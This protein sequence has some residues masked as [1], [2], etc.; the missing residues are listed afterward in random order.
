MKKVSILMF[1]F[2]LTLFV[3]IKGT[4]AYVQ[5]YDMEFTFNKT[6]GYE[7]F[8][9]VERFTWEGQDWVKLVPK[10]GS[11]IYDIVIGFE[12]TSNRLDDD[13]V[14]YRNYITPQEMT[15]IA[16]YDPRTIDYT[17]QFD[18]IMSGAM[19]MYTYDNAINMNGELLSLGAH[20]YNDELYIGFDSGTYTDGYIDDLIASDRER[21]LTVYYSDTQ[22]LKP[23]TVREEV[24]LWLQA[25]YT[26]LTYQEGY[27]VG[28]SEGYDDGYS[29]GRTA[30]IN[31]VHNEYIVEDDLNNDGFGDFSYTQ[32]FNAFDVESFKQEVWRSQEFLAKIEEARNE[33]FA[34]GYESTEAES[35]ILQFGGGF[36]GSA[37]TFVFALLT[38]FELFGI[39]GL[40]V[41]I[42]FIVLGASVIALKFIF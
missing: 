13:T 10:S 5:P 16:G 40:E 31:Y 6:T 2:V 35:A 19:A 9:E 25:R 27:D 12:M 21:A 14:S 29:T 38:N 34:D 18:N 15:I 24:E 23:S 20:F 37:L 17:T 28:V 42:G 36:L 1:M 8:N 30:G 39:N 7:Y 41:L 22:D 3:S 33:G 11:L 32:G 26:S 4:F